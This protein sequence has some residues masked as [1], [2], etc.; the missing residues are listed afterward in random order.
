MKNIFEKFSGLLVV[1]AMVGAAV[2]LADLLYSPK[3]MKKRGYEVKFASNGKVVKKVEKKVDIAALIKSADINRGAKVFRKCATCHNVAKGAKNKVGPN[4]YRIVGRMKASVSGF[5]YSKAMK[6]KGG[7]WGYN[8]LSAF[9][10]KPKN[11]VPGTKMGFAGLKK[12]KDR[13]DVIAYLENKR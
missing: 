2:L 7:K 5:S 8:E 9:L 4:L 13:A 11:Y 3:E 10:K 12:A 6:N 1:V